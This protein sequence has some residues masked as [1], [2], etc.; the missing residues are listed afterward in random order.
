MPE[1]DYRESRK[2]DSRLNELL[3]FNVNCPVYRKSLTTVLPP[4]GTD[5]IWFC[6]RCH[7]E[8]QDSI[9]F[10]YICP[11]CPVRDI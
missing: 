11:L 8:V 1:W 10:F 6:S 2:V 4:E 9:I 7:G 3:N 5:G